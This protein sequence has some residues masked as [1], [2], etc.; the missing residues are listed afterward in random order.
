MIDADQDMFDAET[1]Q[2]RKPDMPRRGRRVLGD[3]G[4]E[5]GGPGIEQKLPLAARGQDQAPK[6]PM[7]G[8]NIE[9]ENQK[10]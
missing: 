7:V 8:I 5:L 1:D 3:L 6:A 9:E 4:S 2:P 10:A